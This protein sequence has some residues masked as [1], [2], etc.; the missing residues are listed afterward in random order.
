MTVGWLAVVGDAAYHA[1][2]HHERS[3]R[4]NAHMKE[5]TLLK[6]IH[7]KYDR[8]TVVCAQRTWT[9]VY[10]AGDKGFRLL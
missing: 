6:D 1:M 4:Y 7:P 2:A 8:C 5:V 9:K 10:A 3:G